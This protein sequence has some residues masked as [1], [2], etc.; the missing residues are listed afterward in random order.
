[1]LLDEQQTCW[2]MCFDG[3]YSI[4]PSTT[5]GIPRTMV[6]VGIVF[7]TLA[8]D[9][10]QHAILISELRTNNEAEYE[11]LILGLEIVISINIEDLH[12]LGD[13]QLNIN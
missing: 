13:S 5:S 6:G 3:V 7:V 4:G 2:K 8:E 12:I 11:A 9:I 10:I 1:M